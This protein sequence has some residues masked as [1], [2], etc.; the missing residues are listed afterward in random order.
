MVRFIIKRSLEP[1]AM[2]FDCHTESAMNG[3]IGNVT[4]SDD[5]VDFIYNFQMGNIQFPIAFQSNII[6]QDCR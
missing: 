4:R 1:L 2:S 6:Y 5:Q 3:T